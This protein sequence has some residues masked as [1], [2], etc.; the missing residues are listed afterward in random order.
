[1]TRSNRISAAADS[2]STR[3]PVVGSDHP[4]GHPPESPDSFDHVAAPPGHEATGAPLDGE[5]STSNMDAA[6]E[7][8]DG[9]DTD[10]SA[11]DST[12]IQFSEITRTIWLVRSDNDELM[13][14]SR[15]QP[16][17]LIGIR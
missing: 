2:P 17:R 7:G 9:E 5:L 10:L 3:E 8:E 1:M 4:L 11:R 6:P 12:D 14:E 16:Y 15:Y 13:M